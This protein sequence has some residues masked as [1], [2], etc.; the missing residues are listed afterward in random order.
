MTHEWLKGRKKKQNNQPAIFHRFFQMSNLFISTYKTMHLILLY[1]LSYTIFL[2]D[3]PGFLL[4]IPL[5]FRFAIVFLVLSPVSST[6]YALLPPASL[7]F[8]GHCECSILKADCPHYVPKII[9]LYLSQ[10]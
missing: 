2:Q 9:L 1:S 3:N 6:Y 10:C 4:L 8:I 5:Q 7:A